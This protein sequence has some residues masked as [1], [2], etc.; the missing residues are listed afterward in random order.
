MLLPDQPGAHPHEVIAG[1]KGGTVYLVDRD[2]MGHVGSTNDNQIVQSLINVFPTGGS[3][4]T[5][6]YSAPVYFN[7]SVYFAPGE[8]AA[9]GVLADERPALDVARPRSRPRPTTARRSTFSRARRRDRGLCQRELERDPV[10]P[11]EQ[12]RQ[13]PG[14]VARLRPEQPRARVLHSDQA[15][16]RDQLDPWLKF[17]IPLVANGRVYVVSAGQLTAFG[18]LP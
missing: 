11:A 10:G 13:H 14:N 5:G 12:R 7:G 6:N 1:G 9:D 17:T 15:G 2:N 16:T 4:N 3:Y 8:Q 18:L